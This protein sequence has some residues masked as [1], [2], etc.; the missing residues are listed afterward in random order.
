MSDTLQS[1][2]PVVAENRTPPCAFSR[3]TA[4]AA[5]SS[6]AK[7]P[8]SQCARHATVRL[9]DAGEIERRCRLVEPIESPAPE[10]RD[11]DPFDDRVFC[12]SRC[13]PAPPAD[14]QP[15]LAA[16]VEEEPR[17]V[18][19]VDDVGRLQLVEPSPD[20]ARASPTSRSSCPRV[21]SRLAS[22]TAREGVGDAAG[23]TVG[24]TAGVR[25]DP[26]QI[27]TAFTRT[28][29][30]GIERLL[31]EERA[32]RSSVVS[33]AVR[34]VIGEDRDMSRWAADCAAAASGRRA[35]TASVTAAGRRTPR[36]SAAADTL[37]R[38]SAVG[39]EHARQQLDHR[40]QDE[41]FRQE[42]QRHRQRRAARRTRPSACIPRAGARR[43]RSC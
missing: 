27:P 19:R 15:R 17:H 24:P 8:D 16:A 33:F 42:R 31:R 26:R 20:D 40:R 11:V 37:V 25:A 32:T 22:C 1:T 10:H 12:D 14:R 28:R 34:Q 4:G 41:H 7:S 39:A 13:G 35:S 9:A 2:R 29:G 18:E 6:A 23:A 3:V 21:N 5:R 38:R 36:R 30:F 43:S